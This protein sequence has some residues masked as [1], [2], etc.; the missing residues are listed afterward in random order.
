[1]WICHDGVKPV[2]VRQRWPL[3]STHQRM[4]GNVE[5]KDRYSEFLLQIDRLSYLYSFLRS[6]EW[7]TN[8]V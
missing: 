1:M 7:L 3:A 2:D 5:E 4:F 6:H 8:M